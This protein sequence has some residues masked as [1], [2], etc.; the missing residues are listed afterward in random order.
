MLALDTLQ[1][2]ILDPH[3][4]GFA[5]PS[6]HGHTTVEDPTRAGRLIVFG[7]RGGSNWNTQV[8]VGMVVGCPP[9]CFNPPP[10]LVL[11]SVSDLRCV[12]P[13]QPLSSQR[14]AGGLLQTQCGG[15]PVTAPPAVVQNQQSLI[16]PF[17]L[18]HTDSWSPNQTT[19]T[20]ERGWCG[21]AQQYGRCRAG[22]ERS[23]K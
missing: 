4:L 23:G 13:V 5:A 20:P 11:L 18:S 1:W 14:G 22:R 16:G 15:P 9:L 3:P 7:G 21:R 12:Q 6:L 2:S 8:C 19:P 10:S 17:D